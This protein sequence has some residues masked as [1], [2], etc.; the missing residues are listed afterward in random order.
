MV[1]LIA[2]G[3]QQ[4]YEIDALIKAMPVQGEAVVKNTSVAPATVA[5]KAALTLRSPVSYTATFTVSQAKDNQN[6]LEEYDGSKVLLTV[7][8]QL[9]SRRKQKQVTIEPVN[10]YPSDAFPYPGSKNTI[11]VVYD[12]YYAYS[13]DMAKVK[14]SRVNTQIGYTLQDQASA[15]SAH[16]LLRKKLAT[17]VNHP[18][19]VLRDEIMHL[20]WVL[21]SKNSF[22][23]DECREIIYQLDLSETDPYDSLYDLVSVN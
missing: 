13:R 19:P 18:N 10:Q 9:V 21:Y 11:I 2:A 7:G 12:S 1:C 20:A 6:A 15:Q 17:W 14:K 3:L 8:Q 16:A 23:E 4:Y 22:T 5:K